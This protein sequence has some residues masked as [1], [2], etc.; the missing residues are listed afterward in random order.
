MPNIDPDTGI[1][2]RVEPDRSLRKHRDVD[3]GAP[4]Y[5]CLGMQLCPM[6]CDADDPS[7]REAVLEVGM[8]LSVLQRGSHVYI[9][10]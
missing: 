8:E 7:K 1:R 5:G 3:E 10:Q 9:P 4:K 2:H 6:F